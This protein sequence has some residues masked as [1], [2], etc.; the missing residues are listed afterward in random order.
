MATVKI[1]V[2]DGR[3]CNDDLVCKFL[4]QSRF[5]ASAKPRCALMDTPLDHE[6]ESAYVRKCHRCRLETEA[7]K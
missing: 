7:V 5:D 6:P 1:T 3:H 2:P 4:R